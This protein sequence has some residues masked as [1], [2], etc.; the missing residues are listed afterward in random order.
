MQI[1][2]GFRDI[3]PPESLKRRKIREVIENQF[4]AYGFL[5]LETPSIEC[6]ELLKSE[7]EETQAVSDR[8]RLK[9]K[10][11]RNLGLRY[12]FTVQ[13]SRI[14]KENPSIKLPFRRYQIG[15]VFRDEALKPGK[16]REFMQCDADIIGDE[17]INADAECIALAASILSELKIKADIIINNRK[18]LNSILESIGIKSKT[19]QIFREIDKLDKL[20]EREVRQNLSKL[21]KPDQI[22]KIFILLKKDLQYFLKNK[23]EGAE[24]IKQLQDL[25]KFYGYKIK[26]RPSMV[27]G[28]AYYTGNIFEIWSKD[29][30]IALGGGGRYDDKVGKYI[31]KKIPAVGISFGKLLDYPKIEIKG[32]KAV[33]IS[34]GQER[35]SLKILRQLR[36]NQIPSLMFSGKV[37]KALEYANSYSIPFVIFLGK[38]EIKKKKVKIRNMISGKEELLSI[39]NVISKLKKK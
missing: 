3:F 27:R 20:S 19:Q 21:I 7:S 22:N 15:Y 6:D 25:G 2:K 35:D 38:E 18:L 31:G 14:F 36:K 8:F 26:F 29:M 5:P 10:G 34:I 37:S 24:E 30:N 11:G 9:D 13:L 33:L 12:E 23:F 4:K 32:I 17:S 28:F 39:K 16:Y 1:V